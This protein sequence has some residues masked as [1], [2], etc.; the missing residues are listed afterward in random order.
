MVATAYIIR[1]S[2]IEEMFQAIMIS[3][4]RD[5]PSSRPVHDT[6]STQVASVHTTLELI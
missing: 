3:L 1:A 4:V 5:F 6:I 2:V